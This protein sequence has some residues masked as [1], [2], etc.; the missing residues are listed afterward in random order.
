VITPFGSVLRNTSNL[1]SGRGS[2][3]PWDLQ[4]RSAMMASMSFTRP[5]ETLLLLSPFLA[6]IGGA[7]AAIV[8][9]A[10]WPGHLAI[11]FGVGAIVTWLA[12]VT[13]AIK[14]GRK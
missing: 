4:A 3:P 9:S 13:I 2:Q 6:G 12:L 8:M 14:T 7:F 11:A 10:V 5:H 1:A